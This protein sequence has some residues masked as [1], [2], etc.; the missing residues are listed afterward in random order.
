[1]AGFAGLAHP[2][3]YQGLGLSGR[4][5]GLGYFLDM[6]EHLVEL[7]VIAGDCV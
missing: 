7:K 5:V 2:L 4:Q 6:D 3:I 1:M